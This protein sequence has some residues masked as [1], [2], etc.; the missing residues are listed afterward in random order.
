MASWYTETY[1]TNMLSVLEIQH[2]DTK[3]KKVYG[4]LSKRVR[5]AHLQLR[6]IHK[7][8]RLKIVL[9]EPIIIHGK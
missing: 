3:S 4:E 6:D 8:Q 2:R 7:L 5:E 1:H 9:P